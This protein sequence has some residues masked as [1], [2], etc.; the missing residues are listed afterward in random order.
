MRHD[1]F[2]GTKRSLGRNRSTAANCRGRVPRPGAGGACAPGAGRGPAAGRHNSSRSHILPNPAKSVRRSFAVSHA[3]LEA[4]LL[5]E[6]FKS[7]RAAG[8]L[9]AK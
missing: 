5:L 7:Q 2:H 3:R 4:P 6:Q 1:D 9:P 8:A